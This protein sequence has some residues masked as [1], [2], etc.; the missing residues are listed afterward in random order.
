MRGVDHLR[1]SSGVPGLRGGVYPLLL[2]ET[3]RFLAADFDGELGAGRARLHRDV[4]GPGVPA[5]LER[6]RSGG[7]RT[8]LDL[9]LEPVP[10]REAR[11]LGDMLITETMDRRP[12][13]G[14]SSY[15]RLF[16]SQDTIPAGGPT[17]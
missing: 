13:I 8:R 16:P 3:C 11:Q 12:E 5:A 6:S 7:G 10:A 9:L 1:S 17:T 4:P 2:D 14:F 15:D